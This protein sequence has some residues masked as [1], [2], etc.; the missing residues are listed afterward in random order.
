MP[1]I[2]PIS[3]KTI[4]FNPY[5]FTP[6]GYNAQSPDL[7]ILEKSLANRE[8]RMTDAYS[9]QAARNI[10]LGEIETKLNPAESQWINDYKKDIN[11]QIQ[12]SIDLGDFGNAIRTATSLAGKVANDSA[13]L[14]RIDAN[15]KYQ[16]WRNNIQQRVD[17]GE[18]SQDAAKWAI[19]TN[20][21]QFEE[22]KDI[23]GNIIGGNLKD[24]R[25]IYNTINWA[26]VAAKAAALNRPDVFQSDRGGGGNNPAVYSSK[27]EVL[28]ELTGQ[29]GASSS[30]WRESYQHEE[31][32]AGEILDTI[33]NLLNMPDLKNQ[34]IQDYD[35]SVWNY[36]QQLANGKITD[37]DRQN[38]IEQGLVKNGSVVPLAK[39]LEDKKNLFVKAL[40]YNK[41]SS[42]SL[43]ENGFSFAGSGVG[44]KGKG[45]GEEES[46]PVPQQPLHGQAKQVQQNNINRS[47][48]SVQQSANTLSSQM[49]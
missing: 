20:P 26:D 28:K 30:S 15:Q 42:T 11:Q 8:K 19:A 44:G 2:V 40:A 22:T 47:S 45:Q 43:K 12:N 25:Q 17:K 33:G 31:V 37:T 13:I 35:V 3:L 49:Q 27:E 23:Y 39:Y 36:Q 24:Q 9:Q 32:T 46:E 18:I 29:I 4:Q 38:L 6:V 14:S 5:T 48:E 1:E 7:S 41:T 34:A 21:Y 10:Q 16:D